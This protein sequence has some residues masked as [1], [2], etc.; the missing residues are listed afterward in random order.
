MKINEKS[1]WKTLI[2]FSIAITILIIIFIQ[3]K[4]IGIYKPSY[5]ANIPICYK[6]FG[7]VR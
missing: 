2:F 5:I 4:N 7:R 6:Q 3:D 1:T